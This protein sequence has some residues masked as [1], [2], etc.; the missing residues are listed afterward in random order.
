MAIES[1]GATKYF[2]KRCSQL[3]FGFVAFAS[4][5][6]ANAEI[7]AIPMPGDT[8]LVIFT[9]DANDTYTVLARPKSVTDISIHP[10]ES[11]VAMAVG[12]TSQW[13]VSKA[14]GHVFI[15]P[16]RP[17]I[18]TTATIVTD[19]RTYQLT[20]RAS[21]EDGKFYQRVSWDYPDIVI[22]QQE[23]AARSKLAS[24]TER[25]RLDATVVTP[26]IA[27]E[28]LNF[29]YSIKGD[30]EFKPQQV[31]DDG[32]FTWIRMPAT[33]EMPA[34]FLKPESGDAELLNYNMRGQFLV[35]QRLVPRLLLKSG[36]SEII[37]TNNK[38]RPSRGLFGWGS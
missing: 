6:T 28:K 18:A 31:F 8:K 23:Q 32:K 2:W 26:N 24:D 35:I 16:V 21:P 3:L 34:V 22:F 38:L 4:A 11:I 1:R 33:Q 10:D 20:L 12:D 5:L 29:D 7:S 14:N 36:E 27:L 37:I 19:R 25:N 17:D 13:I 30:A 15:K 9:F